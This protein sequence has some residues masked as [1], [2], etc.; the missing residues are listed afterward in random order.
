M[1]KLAML[2]LTGMISLSMIACNSSSSNEEHQSGSVQVDATD[3]GSVEFSQEETTEAFT[4]EETEEESTIDESA[5]SANPGPYLKNLFDFKVNIGK[6]A[7][8]IPIAYSAMIARNWLYEDDD[9]IT[10]K[11]NQYTTEEFMDRDD[12]ILYVSFF[13]MGIN[14]QQIKDSLIGQV[15]FDKLNLIGCETE[16]RFAGNIIYGQSTKTDVIAAYGEPTRIEEENG[17][18]VL[19]Y[20]KGEFEW[21]KFI[22]DEGTEIINNVDMC[23]FVE[24]DNFD[25]G[26]I[27]EEVPEVVLNYKEPDAVGTDLNISNVRVLGDIYSL[28]APVSAF[29]ENGWEIVDD[30]S[31]QAVVA[32]G[33]GT[34]TLEKKGI[35]I[36][37]D[38]I[39]YTDSAVYIENCFVTTVY[40]DL[41]E[42]EKGMIYIPNEISV[43]MPSSELELALEGITYETSKDRKYTYYTI[44]HEG[45]EGNGFIIRVNTSSLIVDSISCQNMP[46][47]Y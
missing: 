14:T 46:S 25:G 1:K 6:I 3:E 20:E 40:I 21:V 36:T 44:K 13:N 26:T 15:T 42:N 47:S 10:L 7:Y 29:L 43:N 33:V 2:F 35:L 9:T 37:S 11:P 4:E 28:P 27:N 5:I 38:V 12:V 23:N 45:V 24:P 30:A 22:P 8:R 18:E 17:K 34:I 31:H 39:N 16:I 19:I 32:K 41:E